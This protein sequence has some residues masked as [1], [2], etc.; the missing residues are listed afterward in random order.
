MFARKGFA[1]ASLEEIADVAG[2]TTGALYYHF[3]SKQELFVELMRAGWT[4]RSAN[5]AEA[6]ARVAA[7]ENTDPYPEFSR[8]LAQRAA[9][10]GESGP[11]QGEFWLYALRNPEVMAVVAEQLRDQAAGLRP[12]IE[13]LMERAGTAPGITADELATVTM[14]LFQGLARRR[15]MDSGS[16]PDDLF[17]RVLERLFAP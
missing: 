14:A 1:G 7:D 5:W 10:A 9:R 17:A 6:A 8:L 16:V 12:A 4:R 15:R 2:Y 3:A 11:L 13:I